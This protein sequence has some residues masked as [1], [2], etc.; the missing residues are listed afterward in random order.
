MCGFAALWIG[1]RGNARI[2]RLGGLALLCLATAKVFLYDLSNM[3]G[4]YRIVSFLGLGVSLILVSLFY[5]R[6]VFRKVEE[7]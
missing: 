6:F 2:V 7:R 4:I 5:Q 3:T 1:L